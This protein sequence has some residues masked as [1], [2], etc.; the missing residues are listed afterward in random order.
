MSKMLSFDAPEFKDPAL[1]VEALCALGFARER[2]TVGERRALI[3]WYGHPAH[4]RPADIV[5]GRGHHERD[6]AMLHADIGFEKTPTG[7]RCHLDHLDRPLG[8]DTAGFL[9]RLKVAYGERAAHAIAQRVNGT[10]QRRVEGGKVV[11]T[12]RCA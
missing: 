7:Y 2:I 8:L 9:T 1:I 3:D 12:I 5:V 11:L 10:I 6:G 4:D